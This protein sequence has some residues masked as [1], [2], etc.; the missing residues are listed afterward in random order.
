MR[1]LAAAVVVVALASAGCGG[2]SSPAASNGEASKPAKQVLADA[3]KA[4]NAASS[5][6]MSGYVNQ[7]VLDVTVEKGKRAMGTITS[8]GRKADVVVIGNWNVGPCPQCK[9]Y[10]HASSEFWAYW[11]PTAGIS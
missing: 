8:D 5:V 6:H 3:V 4:A 11:A 9:A 7:D 1:F 10:L 2:G